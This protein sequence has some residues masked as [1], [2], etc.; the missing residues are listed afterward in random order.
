MT[1]IFGIEIEIFA[2]VLIPV[3]GAV[4][5]TTYKIIRYFMKK[6]ICFTLLKNT[7]DEQQEKIDILVKYDSS[8]NEKHDQLHVR[9]DHL[10][11]RMTKV[12]SKL[13]LLLTHFDLKE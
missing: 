3:S 11:E 6:E 4:I 13:D 1:S 9:D 5:V 12:E 8:S 2:G 7:V 10:S